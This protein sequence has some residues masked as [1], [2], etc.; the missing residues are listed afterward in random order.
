MYA[1][2]PGVRTLHKELGKEIVEKVSIQKKLRLIEKIDDNG[3]E[4]YRPT[5]RAFLECPKAKDDVALIYSYL[6]ML[7]EKFNQNPEIQKTT[8]VEI[9]K[10]LKLSK[11]QSKRLMKLIGLGRLWGRKGASWG[12]PWEIGIQDDIEELIKLGN[13]KEYLTKRLEK[14]DEKQKENEKRYSRKPNYFQLL[15][16]VSYNINVWLISYVFCL[17][18]PKIFRVSRTI[19]IWFILYTICKVS[20]DVFSKKIPFV[21]GKKVME[22]TLWWIV[23]IGISVFVGKIT[24]TLLK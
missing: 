10:S 7:K 8:S 18:F 17:N 4:C 19:S 16:W 22:K 20:E 21:S 14:E 1:T 15:P 11:E 2:W 23:S 12:D 6:E 9:E 24:G 5:F 3:V 13:P